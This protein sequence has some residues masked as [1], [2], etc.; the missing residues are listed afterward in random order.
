MDWDESE[1]PRH[2]AKAPAGRGG[3]F[4]PKGAKAVRD[5]ATLSRSTLLK[6]ARERGLV[7]PRGHP[8]DSIRQMIRR[9]DS[10]TEP[11]WVE[12]AGKRIA[13]KKAPK[14]EA[15]GAVTPEDRQRAEG[16]RRHAKVTR[17]LGHMR[18]ANNPK[19]SYHHTRGL[20][21]LKEAD[22][23]ENEADRL[24]PPEHLRGLQP[25]KAP[26]K[27]AASARSQRLAK[28]LEFAGRRSG[29]PYFR[30]SAV[31]A[32]TAADRRS[33][34]VDDREQLD[35]IVRQLLRERDPTTEPEVYLRALAVARGWGLDVSDVD[36]LAKKAASKPTVGVAFNSRK[37]SAGT[38]VVWQPEGEEPVYGTVG[39]MGR[40][41]VVDWEGGKREKVRANVN[42]PDIRVVGPD[43]G[44]APGEIELVPSSV[45][46]PGT[47]RVKRGGVD[48]GEIYV[49][50]QGDGS[51][52]AFPPDR[53]GPGLGPRP[54]WKPTRDEAVRVL[55]DIASGS[56]SDWA[57]RI[58]ARIPRQERPPEP[59]EFVEPPVRSAAWDHVRR[60]ALPASVR[61]RVGAGTPGASERP[62]RG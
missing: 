35:D 26:V 1:H 19:G 50:P 60:P 29:N 4:R 2:P 18:I 27:K 13:A 10:G 15:A 38:R 43:E 48:I 31:Q 47:F 53:G 34:S 55:V 24:D 28:A 12:E 36:K 61:V 17:D 49:D 41:T 3:E 25:R 54:T 52:Y 44:K 7:V 22:Q 56:Q 16:L 20:A 40:F 9:F 32:V 51:A 62:V 6:Y 5:L 45:T 42:H 39:K 59:P 57:E 23:M 11:G 37:H 8:D 30:V 14:K 58:D 33:L 46:K 21:D